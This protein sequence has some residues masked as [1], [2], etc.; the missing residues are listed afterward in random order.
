VL[1]AGPTATTIE[2]GDVD[3]R[4]LGVLSTCLRAPTTEGEDV[5]DGPSGGVLAACPAAATT[6]V[7]D[8]IDERSGGA[9]DISGSSHHRSP[10]GIH[11]VP[12]M[13]VWERPPST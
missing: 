1:A 5:D 12:E 6:D 7:G 3:G 4:P 13:K 10:S 9:A 8:V 2:V 11:E